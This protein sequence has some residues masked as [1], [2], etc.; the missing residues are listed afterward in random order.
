MYDRETESYWS[1]VTGIAIKGKY[2]GAQLKSLPVQ[3]LK[4][5]EWKK[6]HPDS[7]VLVK[8]RF[9]TRSSYESYNK[10]RDR[11]GIVG[12]VN[13]DRR[14]DGKDKVLR[15][16]GTFNPHAPAVKD[17]L[18]L[19]HAFFDVRDLVQVKYEMLRR[20]AEEGWSVSRAAGVFGFSRP[21]YYKARR[22]FD[23]DGLWGLLSERRGPHGPH[24]LTDERASLLV[25][26]LL[27]DPHLTWAELAEELERQTGLRVH[28]RT[29]KRH[30]EAREKKR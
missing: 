11:L 23:A 4:W 15:E 6:I 20:V 21:T 2:K 8:S 3:H 7:K 16:S 29:I 25:G 30:F 5:S 18:F 22:T 26:R 14:L 9:T 27:E 24:K 17:P 12:T 1:H 13:F 28:P 10:S 19:E